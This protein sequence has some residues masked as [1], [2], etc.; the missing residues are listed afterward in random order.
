MQAVAIRSPVAS[1]PIIIYV[2]NLG[3]L[4]VAV[5]GTSTNKVPVPP[6]ARV[7]YN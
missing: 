3:I 2:L 4:W 5:V 6:D 1:K 7:R